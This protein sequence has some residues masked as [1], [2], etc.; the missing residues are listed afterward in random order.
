MSSRFLCK[1][2]TRKLLEVNIKKMIGYLTRKVFY[3]NLTSELTEIILTENGFSINQP[4]GAKPK[5]YNWEDLQ[6]IRFSDNY[7]EVIVEKS[8]GQIALNN[9][10]IGWYELI[11]YVP[12]TFKEFDFKYVAELI[13]SLKPCGVCGIVAVKE[14][15]CLVCETVAWNEEMNENKFDYLKSKQ[16][17]FYS[18]RISNGKEVKKIAEPEHGFKA[19]KNWRLYI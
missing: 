9:N 15:K 10:H 6:T 2:T 11:Q 1:K 19:D 13:D 3:R 18:D 4:F 8:D 16:S 12:S 14:N 17:E 5:L 7:N